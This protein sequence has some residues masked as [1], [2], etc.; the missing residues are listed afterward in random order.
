MLFDSHCHLDND[1]EGRTPADLV[2]SAREAGVSYLMSI[3]TDIASSIETQKIANQ[4]SDVYFSAGIHP[5]E[6]SKH[7]NESMST[8]ETLLKDPKCRAVG[9]LGLDYYYDLSEPEAQ[10]QVLKIQ[11][12]LAKEHQFPVVVHSRDAEADLLPYLQDYAKGLSN[13]G[14]IHCFT[15]TYEFGKACLDLGF[16]ISFSGI[17]TFKN[18]KDLAHSASLYPLER[19]LVET[20]APF[21]APVPYRGKKCEPYMV[22]MTALKLAEL[23]GVSFDKLAEITTQNAKNLFRI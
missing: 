11:L 16:Y 8:L 23:K 20:D 17:L 13:P 3:G 15:G 6:A 22:K 9:E 14:V 12:D 5:H 10:K 21:L 7:L 19:L 4:F 2:Q 1:Y 18:A